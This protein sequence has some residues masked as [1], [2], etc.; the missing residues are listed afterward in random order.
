MLIA[1]ALAAAL[2]LPGPHLVAGNVDG[3]LI[4]YVWAQ[5]GDVTPDPICAA[6][7]TTFACSVVGGA[8]TQITVAVDPAPDLCQART[9]RVRAAVDGDPPAETAGATLPPL[10]FCVYLPEVRR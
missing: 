7:Y 8:T 6:T 10:A 5:Q 1:L 9:I 2:A 4:T 3:G